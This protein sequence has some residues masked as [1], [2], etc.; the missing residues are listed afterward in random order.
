[1]NALPNGPRLTPEE[2][3]ERVRA[4]RGI[5]AAAR[6]LLPWAAAFAE[7][8]LSGFAVG[9]VAVGA[10]GAAYAGANLEFAGAPLGASVHAEQSAVANAWLHGE[11][12][13]VAL[14][15]SAQ[16]CGH[17]RQFLI[18]LG[19]ADRLAIWAAGAP[20][21]TLAALLPA[22]FGP[23]DLGVRATLLAA[24]TPP[25]TSDLDPDD[26]LGGAALEAAQRSYAPY[27]HAYAGAA[28]RL[29][30]GTI[31]GGS[32]AESA[33]F[34]PSLPALQCALVERALWR[35]GDTPVVEA[36]LVEAPA[37]SSQRRAAE[38]LLAAIGGPRLRFAAARAAS[39]GHPPRTEGVEG[40][41]ADK[42]AL[43]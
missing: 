17:C 8:P 24:P 35:R 30:D 5:E 42:S 12:A 25:L 15:A 39:E 38:A 34:N 10:S 14:A 32:Y 27:S 18:E 1:M 11:R 19:D 20:A 33:A 3:T 9:A 28:L 29:A 13:V 36:V 41:S 2:M 37:R 22:A 31:V 43:S 4:S 23:A 7:V 16:P 26:P 21:A 40:N 6:G